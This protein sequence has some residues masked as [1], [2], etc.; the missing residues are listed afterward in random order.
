MSNEGQFPNAQGEEKEFLGTGPMCRYAEDLLPMF[1]VMA[2][3]AV[4]R[5]KLDESVSSLLKLCTTVE[6]GKH[7]RKATTRLIYTVLLFCHL[8]LEHA[9]ALMKLHTS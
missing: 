1:K 8:C 3:P 2:G 4:N 9:L 6:R 5:L 7:L